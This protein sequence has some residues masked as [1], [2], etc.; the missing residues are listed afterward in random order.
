MVNVPNKSRRFDGAALKLAAGIGGFDIGAFV[1][2][3][4]GGAGGGFGFCFH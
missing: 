4:G 2:G 1:G 3:L